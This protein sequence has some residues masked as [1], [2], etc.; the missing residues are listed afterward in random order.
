[1]IPNLTCSENCVRASNFVQFHCPDFFTDIS[2]LSTAMATLSDADVFT[3]AAFD[4]SRGRDS[5]GHAHS[6][7]PLCYTASLSARAVAAANFHP[8]QKKFRPFGAPRWKELQ[9]RRDRFFFFFRPHY[10]T[11]R[12]S[13]C[14]FVLGRLSDRLWR[15]TLR[16]SLRHSGKLMVNCG[17][18]LATGKMK[19]T[20]HWYLLFAR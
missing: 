11:P 12:K 19:S 4:P 18:L 20:C 2:E 3:G 8:A 7:Y 6:S 5:I 14:F 15:N 13:C 10:L 9:V 1:M 16:H 17:H